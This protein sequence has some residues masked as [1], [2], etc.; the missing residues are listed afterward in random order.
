MKKKTSWL[1]KNYNNA[2]TLLTAYDAV[3]ARLISTTTTD[4]ILVGDSLGNTTQGHASTVPVTLDDML[5]HTKAVR[6]GAPAHYI[7]ADMPFLT[8]SIG[9]EDSIRNAGQLIQ[10]GADAVKLEIMSNRQLDSLRAITDSGIAVISHLGFT[11]QA[12]SRIGGYKQQGKTEADCVYYRRLARDS[13][14]A[15]AIALLLELMPDALAK[16][17]TEA[18][19]IPVIGV[20]AGPFCDGQG[21]VT[22]DVLG[23]SERPPRFATAYCDGAGIITAALNSFITAVQSKVQ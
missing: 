14:Q 17:I 16:S 10:A 7:V 13:I 15:G 23:L 5:Y 8:G 1:E 19:E 12:L 22:Y 21:L 20:G 6:R 2:I 9:I 11:P 3:L 18:S 4:I